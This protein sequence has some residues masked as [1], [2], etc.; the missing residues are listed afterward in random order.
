MLSHKF[1]LYHIPLRNSTTSGN[2]WLITLL[3]AGI[4]VE[5]SPIRSLPASYPLYQHLGFNL[6]PSSLFFILSWRSHLA[7]FHA[8]VVA[9]LALGSSSNSMDYTYLLLN[10]QSI[11]I[12]RISRRQRYG[13]VL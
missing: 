9:K 13:L 4:V 3:P 2:H 1:R 12:M 8:Y 11:A 7:L 6:M 10:M 5:V